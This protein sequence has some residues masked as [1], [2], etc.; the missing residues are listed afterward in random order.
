MVCRIRFRFH[1][2]QNSV[3]LYKTER[4]QPLLFFEQENFKSPKKIITNRIRYYNQHRENSS[5]DNKFP[6]KHLKKKKELADHNIS[7]N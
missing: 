3:F 2:L 7:Y 1:I 5:F 4:G 6:L